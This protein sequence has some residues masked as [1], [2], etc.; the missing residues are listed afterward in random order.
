MNRV[1]IVGGGVAGISLAHAFTR[2]GVDIRLMD[3]G[4]NACSSVAAGIVNPFS[5]RRTLLTWNACPYYQEA[6]DFYT[7]MERRLQIQIC[8]PIEIRRIFSSQE[9]ASVWNQRFSDPSFNSFMIPID[10]KDEQYLP[11]GSGKIK[12]FWVDAAFFVKINQGYFDQQGK[13]IP[14]SFCSDLFFPEERRYRGET[15]S[16]VIF[17]LG[18]RNKELPW[19]REVP[20]QSTQGEVLTVAWDNFDE[21]T[22]IHRKVYALPVKK[23]VFK[24]GAT[25]RWNTEEL[26]TSEVARKELLS[27]F[28]QISNDAVDVMNQE[29][30]IRPT[31]PDRRPF[32][33]EH[34]SYKGIYLFNGLGTKGYLTAPPLAQRFVE[35]LDKF[36]QESL[37]VNPY[38]FNRS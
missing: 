33:G 37:S 22:S 8:F 29:V 25:Y 14:E 3:D 21:N 4:K 36:Q 26:A 38:R 27:K 18:Y 12:G 15:Y 13:L 11:F 6:Y 23:G 28:R 2:K 9:E 7:E 5:F 19:F 31:S 16:K 34:Q 20:V 1:L 30:G 32:I 17:A 10:D 24:I 35:G